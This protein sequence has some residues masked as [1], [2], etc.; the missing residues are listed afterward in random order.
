[1]NRLLFPTVL[2]KD[3]YLVRVCPFRQPEVNYTC[4]TNSVG[5]SKVLSLKVLSVRVKCFGEVVSFET[6]DGESEK[7]DRP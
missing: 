4:I 3:S 7:K 2:C 5:D 1:M 6:R